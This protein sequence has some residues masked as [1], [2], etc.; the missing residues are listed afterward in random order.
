[1]SHVHGCA[2]KRF[3]I[4][5]AEMQLTYT[6]AEVHNYGLEARRATIFKGPLRHYLQAKLHFSSIKKTTRWAIIRDKVDIFYPRCM[7]T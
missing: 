5:A 1:M 7:L 6:L 2:Q 4:D 3:V